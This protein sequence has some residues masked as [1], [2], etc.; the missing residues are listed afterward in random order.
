MI[1]DAEFSMDEDSLRF[2]N[3]VRNLPR[4]KMMDLVYKAIINRKQDALNST[5]SKE[6]KLEAITFIISWFEA[7]EEYEKCN[8][9]KKIIQE[10]K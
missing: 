8:E 7:R 2:F 9:L 10:I 3:S 1:E 5:S 4:E 6:E